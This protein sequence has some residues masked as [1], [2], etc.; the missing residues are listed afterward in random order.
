[1]EDFETKTVVAG[2]TDEVKQ[3]CAALQRQVTTLLLALVVVSGTLSVFLWRQ[4]RYAHADLEALK[5]PAAQIIQSFNKQDK[6]NMD[7]FVARLA[8][9]GRTHADFMPILNKYKITVPSV[10]IATS[11]PPATLTPK[12]AAVPK[13]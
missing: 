7:K 8:D 9:Y 6:A 2:E 1:M 12:A 10:P 11:A 3:Q 4:A 13:K 5:Q